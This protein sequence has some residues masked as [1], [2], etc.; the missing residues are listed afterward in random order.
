[1]QQVTYRLRRA[2]FAGSIDQTDLE[3]RL[4]GNPSA[5]RAA[6]GLRDR[7]RHRR[8]FAG[9]RIAEAAITS[10]IDREEKRLC[11]LRAIGTESI[12]ARQV[13]GCRGDAGTGAGLSQFVRRA[14]GAA[15]RRECVEAS[16][17]HRQATQVLRQAYVKYPEIPNRT[18]VLEAMA[19][20]YLALPGKVDV[21]VAGRA[22]G[23]DI[24]AGE[25]HSA[26]EAAG[27]P[28]A[29]GRDLRFGADHIAKISDAT[30]LRG[31]A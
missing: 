27:R 7:Q 29:A 11:R 1:M 24:R 13:P 25:T 22:G 28:G 26:D 3:V 30:K 19:R 9:G 12:R 16:G 17:D 8:I 18:D 5:T 21:A 10:A 20:N 15:L 6:N 4:Y 23:Q 2:R 14:V 31:A